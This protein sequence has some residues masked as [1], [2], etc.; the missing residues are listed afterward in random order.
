MTNERIN[1]AKTNQKGQV[2]T[3]MQ[4]QK[5]NEYENLLVKIIAKNKLATKK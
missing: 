4:Q 2:C 1:E 3:H 5:N